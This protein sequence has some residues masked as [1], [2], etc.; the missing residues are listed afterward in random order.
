MFN[1]FGKR[2]AKS[3][4]THDDSIWIENNLLWLSKRIIDVA[5]QP[6]FLPTKLY[7]DY[8]F[9]GDEED[10]VYVL[11]TICDMIGAQSNNI[12]ASKHTTLGLAWV[13]K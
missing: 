4:V 2:K 5:K 7:F 10:A 9:K 3:P 8:E 11:D 13:R 1:L 6:T 12:L